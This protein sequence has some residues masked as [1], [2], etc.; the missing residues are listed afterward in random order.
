MDKQNLVYTYTVEYCSALKKNKMLKC[1][2]TWMN[3]KNIVPS[4]RRQT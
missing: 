1:V 3:L 4:E 2:A